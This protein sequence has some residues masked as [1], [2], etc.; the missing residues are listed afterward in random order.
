MVIF[1]NALVT[2]TTFSQSEA[3]KFWLARR[4]VDWLGFDTSEHRYTLN[5]QI[6]KFYIAILN[7]LR[8]FAVASRLDSNAGALEPDTNHLGLL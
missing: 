5:V 2:N 3:V 6:L 4:E 7:E 1:G 8:S